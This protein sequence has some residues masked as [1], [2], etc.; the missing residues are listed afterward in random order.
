MSKKVIRIVLKENIQKLGKSNDVIK[1]ATGYARNFLIPNKMASVAT[2]GILNQQKLYAAIK[3]KKMN[4]AKENARKTQQLLEEI[5]KFS[6]SKKTGD[7]ENIF[8]SVTE[9]EISQIIKNTTDIDVDKQNIFLPEIKTIGLYN[10]EIKLFNQ[11]TANI[12]LQVLPEAT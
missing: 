2:T 9:R 3:E 6:I 4:F 8:G 5:Q 7:G 11:M 10:I 1:V 12:Q